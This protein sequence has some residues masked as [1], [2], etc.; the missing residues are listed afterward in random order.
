MS[1]IYRLEKGA[2]ITSAE[3]DG[4]FK[5]LITRIEK[6]EERYVPKLLT[7][8]RIE[9]VGGDLCFYDTMQQVLAKIALPLPRLVARGEWQAQV[10]Y[11]VSDMVAVAHKLYVCTQAHQSATSFVEDQTHW[12]VLID[13]SELTPP[14]L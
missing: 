3:L 9:L 13:F 5:E 2:P 11:S 7:I 10:P 14:H 1:I 8:E 4:N 6:L 12:A